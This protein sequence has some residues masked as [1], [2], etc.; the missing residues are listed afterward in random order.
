MKIIATCIAVATTFSLWACGVELPADKPNVGSRVSALE[1]RPGHGLPPIRPG[2]FPAGHGSPQHGG[3][4][5]SGTWS[6]VANTPDQIAAGFTML[7]TDGTLMVQDLNSFGN[8]WWKLT[9]D[10]SGSYLHGTWTQRASMPNGYAPLYF[11]SAVLPDGRVIVEGGE[12]QAFVPTWTNQGAIYD[13]TLDSW[14]PVAPPP[15]WTTIGDA[16]SAVLADGRF[17][18]ANCCTTEMAILDPTTLTWT[19]TGTGKADF[20]FDEEGWTLLGNGKLLTVDTNNPADLTH[21]EIFDPSTGVWS[22]AGSTIVKLADFNADF[23]GSW[24]LGAGMLRPDGTVFVA[25]A[26]GQNAIYDS[27]HSSWKVG[28]SFPVLPDE[29]QLDQA[30]GPAALLPNGNVLLAVSAGLFNTP[31]HFYEFDG[32]ALHAVATP[33]DAEF[34]SSYNINLLVLPTG[35]I[36]ETD[37]SADVEIYAPT[38]HPNSSWKP[39]FDDHGLEHLRAGHTASLH[40]TQLHGLSQAVAYGDDAQA[41]TNYPLVRITNCAT[42]HVAFARTHGFSNFSIAPYAV[43]SALFDVPAGIETGPSNL[44]VIAN[45]I[46]SETIHTT[47]S[48]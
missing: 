18:L 38:G 11:A 31:A 3:G 25:G 48:H 34:D 2:Q 14:T 13:P 37:F 7:L 23:S 19:A 8:E 6:A 42:G 44:V 30:D 47:I 29:G 33:A 36:L 4:G 28:P 26:L 43:S 39:E 12:Y 22:S 17:V 20:F 9:P 21:S 32:H 35:E 16:Q 15:G 46:A 5:G 45:G 27:V 24:E 10:A 41:A 1:D 40:G